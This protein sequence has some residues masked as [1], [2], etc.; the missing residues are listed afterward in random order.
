MVVLLVTTS[1]ISSATILVSMH[2]STTSG[3]EACPCVERSYPEWDSIK[4][5]WVAVLSAIP[6]QLGRPVVCRSKLEKSQYLASKAWSGSVS[7]QCVHRFSLNIILVF[8]TSLFGQLPS[9]SAYPISRSTAKSGIVKLLYDFAAPWFLV[10]RLVESQSQ[11][12]RVRT[13]DPKFK[14]TRV[15]DMESDKVSWFL[16]WPISPRPG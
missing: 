14:I 5:T 1:R 9:S 16:D 7:S 2:V 15:Y 11:R 8:L 4:A 12:S 10:F 13:I 6:S 3:D